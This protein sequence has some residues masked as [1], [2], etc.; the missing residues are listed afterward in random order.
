MENVYAELEGDELIFG[1]ELP[2]LEAGAGSLREGPICP[3]A[4]EVL[5]FIGVSDTRD[6]AAVA[7]ALVL[8]AEFN[9]TLLHLRG[10]MYAP[11][12]V[13]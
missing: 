8:A 10:E 4:R 9:F 11:K 3:A 5:K 7:A 12:G 6:F 2:N 13:D 1:V